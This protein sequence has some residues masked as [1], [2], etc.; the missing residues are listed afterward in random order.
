VQRELDRL[1]RNKDR[2]HAR[3]KN[4]GRRSSIDGEENTQSPASP[5]SPAITTKSQVGTTRK[6]NNCGQTGHIKTNKKFGFCSSCNMPAAF[7]TVRPKSTRISKK[8]P[9]KSIRTS[10][11]ALLKSTR[12]SGKA[13][14][15]STRTSRK[16]PY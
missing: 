3:E 1:L 10:G 9:P 11:K 15:K 5:N 7:T 2:R 8:A 16:A 12:T 13:P 14:L 6:C 4:K